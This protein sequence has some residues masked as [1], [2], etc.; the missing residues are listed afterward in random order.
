MGESKVDPR[1]LGQDQQ[2]TNIGEEPNAL[3][4]T[5]SQDSKPDMTANSNLAVISQ[6]NIAIDITSL[7]TGY[8]RY[9]V[10]LTKKGLTKIQCQHTM[11]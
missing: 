4:N 10:A 5:H 1:L 6:T 8:H 3:L 11:T 7:R 2:S 9:D